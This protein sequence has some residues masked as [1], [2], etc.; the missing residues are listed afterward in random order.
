M[1][2]EGENKENMNTCVT[3]CG[4][5]EQAKPSP[6]A[7]FLSAADKYGI[8]MAR[9]SIPPIPAPAVTQKKTERESLGEG[10]LVI[11]PVGQRVSTLPDGQIL[12]LS[13]PGRFSC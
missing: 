1:V 7:S 4:E 12:F 8:P 5:G 3:W 9:F 13:P 6:P 10:P 2:R 11:K